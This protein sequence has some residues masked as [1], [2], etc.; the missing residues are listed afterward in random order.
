L[1]QYAFDEAN[2]EATFEDHGPENDHIDNVIRRW[3]R[4]PPDC[5]LSPEP[6]IG[7][8]A[9]IMEHVDRAF[10]QQIAHRSP[11][12]T[13]P[14]RTASQA[15]SHHERNRLDQLKVRTSHK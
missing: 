6:I 13:Q 5:A 3:K 11:K 2:A 4:A 7:R 12:C 14:G 9:G 8:T 1:N 15:C 10:A